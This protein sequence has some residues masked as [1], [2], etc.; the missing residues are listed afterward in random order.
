MKAAMKMLG[1][2]A[3]VL[4]AACSRP[5][6]EEIETTAK[7]PVVVRVAR[8]GTIR[9]VVTATGVVQPAPGAELLVTAPQAARIAA[10]PKGEG[11]AVRRGELLVRFEIPDL[12]AGVS[13]READLARAR[14]HLETAKAAAERVRG[15]FGRGIAA[16]AE[17]ETAD[18]ELADARAEVAGAESARSA[19]ASLA[20]RREVRAPFSGVIAKRWH[21][22][23]DLVDGA[24]DNPILRLVDPA[25]LQVEADV[26]LA[27]L[28]R[29]TAG[30]AAQVWGPGSAPPAAA[31]VLGRPAAVDP[32]TATAPVRLAFSTAFPFPA[33]TPVRVEIAAEEH[34]DVVLVPAAALVEEGADS[35]LYVV[36]AQ[37]TAHRRPVTVG[38]K[39]GNEAEVQGVAAGDR[40]VIQGQNALPDGAAVTVSPAP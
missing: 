32:A 34:R 1:L 18:R 35:F 36:D 6:S 24:P 28:P 4:L 16:R 13:G 3:L 30:S 31:R 22:P 38:L 27:D 25:R 12:A 7:V 21:N 39:A 17:V 26:P 15:L 8:V 14:A 20:G 11:E 10:L 19:A 5:S 2:A 37:G 29:L 23:G 9:G 33:G 40:V